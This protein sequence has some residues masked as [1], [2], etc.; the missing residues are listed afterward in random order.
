M[1]V[2]YPHCRIAITSVFDGFGGDDTNP[3][4][5]GVDGSLI[6]TSATVERNGFH[7]ADTFTVSFDAR[8]LPF[9]P[10]I[11][12]NALVQLWLFDAGG[13]RFDPAVHL[14]EEQLEIVGVLDEASFSYS[15]DGRE[16]TMEGADL[17]SLVIRKKW[18]T[19]KRVPVGRPLDVTVQQLLDE[20]TGGRRILTVRFNGGDD[21]PTVKRVSAGVTKKKQ[22]VAKAAPTVGS[23]RR[24]S[25]VKRGLPMP[26]GHNYWD[27]VYA[28][29]QQH[30][31]LCFVRGY[32]VVIAKTR[33]L[34]AN[35]LDETP[36]LVYGQNV[37]RLESRRTYSHEAVPQIEVRSY[38]PATKKALSAVWPTNYSGRT[39]GA[40]TLEERR[41]VYTYDG[42]DDA[43]LLSEIARELYA[44]HAKG[45]SEVRV[46]TRSLSDRNGKDLL[47]LRA[48]QPFLVAFDAFNDALLEQLTRPERY[49]YLI[50]QGYDD[51]IAT[52]VSD[53]FDRIR[54]FD[55]PFFLRRVVKRWDRERG[56][57]LELEGINFVSVRRD[58]AGSISP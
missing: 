42:I 56:I 24:Q 9:V 30:G 37:L 11:I 54:Q 29:C 14:T 6:P 4:I 55:K 3:T 26:T 41:K 34:T 52:L 28:L 46:T 39:S 43:N 58:D 38:D 45:E 33:V 35:A 40:G 20:A 32:D 51:R 50:E 1:A 57:E 12:R 47:H 5:L 10:D 2:F 16:F 15:E 17:T 31:Y 21:L 23:G 7:V 36:K 48:G 13:A 49:Q 8:R 18:D 44:D 25:H 53:E 27:V 22:T 19:S